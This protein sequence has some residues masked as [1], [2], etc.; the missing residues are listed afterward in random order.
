[1]SEQGPLNERK[2]QALV[3]KRYEILSVIGQGGMGAVYR[4]KDLKLDREVGLKVIRSVCLGNRSIHERFRREVDTMAKVRHPNVVRFLDFDDTAEF[5]FFTMEYVE[6][7]NLR[8]LL[9]DDT[10]SV[11]ETVELM[12]GL[13]DGLEAIHRQGIIHRDIKPANILVASDGTPK[14]M[15]FGLVKVIEG[16]ESLTELTKT[17]VIVGTLGYLPPEVLL[18][19]IGSPASDVYQI[20]LVFYKALAKRL[21]FENKGIV[22]M[23]KE[24]DSRSVAPILD[25]ALD[26]RLSA[27]LMSMLEKEPEKRPSASLV[28]QEL[29]K[30][31]ADA[32]SESL[33]SLEPTVVGEKHLR[34]STMFPIVLVALI[35]VLLLWRVTGVQVDLPENLTKVTLSKST[36]RGTTALHEAAALGA[37]SALKQ[38]VDSGVPVDGQ[39]ENGCTP[40][41]WAT[42]YGRKDCCDYLLSKEADVNIADWFGRRPLHLAAIHGH[43]DIGKAYLARSAKIDAADLGAQTALHL[44]AYYGHL[45]FVRMLVDNGASL[46]CKDDRNRSVLMMA[47]ETFKADVS[48]F[49]IAA[50][51]DVRSCDDLMSNALHLA[52]NKG[53]TSCIEPIVRAGAP[54][55]ARNSFGFTAKQLAIVHRH[56]ETV[57]VFE[58]LEKR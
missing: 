14:L 38:L 39:D 11:K 9:E 5:A 22:E 44:A 8:S 12:I 58:E 53:M 31:L 4:A 23:I 13:A 57:K 33:P 56:F 16:E 30:W 19:H 47:L 45:K 15:D 35:S 21:P 1:M 20:G 10:F 7:E 41:A 6:G 49:L 18:G 2:L 26:P 46:E 3:A 34:L 28:A 42:I 24:A 37:L 36:T 40:L 54:L 43:L 17:G 48:L 32:A 50:G 51:V 25:P 27:L 52:A 29:R 55:E